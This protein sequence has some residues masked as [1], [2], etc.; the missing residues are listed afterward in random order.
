MLSWLR[1]R[2]LNVQIRPLTPADVSPVLALTRNAEH[3][4][5]H[6]DWWP[7]EHYLGLAPCLVAEE[8]G[9]LVGAL[10]CPPD[11]PP[12]A[13]IRALAVADDRPARQVVTALFDSAG[14]AL[15]AAGVTELA[16]MHVEPWLHSLLPDFGLCPLTRVVTWRAHG[17]AAPARGD[18]AIRVRPASPADMPV[19]A[20]IDSAAFDPP[21]RLSE[22]TLARM[23]AVSSTFTVAE[24]DGTLAGF[25]F[26][27]LYSDYAHLVRVAVRPDLHGRGIAT[28]LLAELF[29]FCSARG[30][31]GMT[32]NTQQ[33]NGTAQKLYMRFGFRVT[34]EATPVWSLVIRR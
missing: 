7:L 19:L 16:V 30:I 24:F 18:P 26:S 23:L 12:A 15:R 8:R 27:S 6:A 33:E 28:R 3:A 17:L 34:Q 10:A 14:P 4:H 21:W 2:T 31:S 13:W 9:R 22:N 25:Q 5:R 1:P 32:L 20:A 29:G 11:P